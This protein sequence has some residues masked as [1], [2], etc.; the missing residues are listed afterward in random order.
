MSNEPDKSRFRIPA[1]WQG[2]IVIVIAYLV[3]DNAFPPVM[4]RTL[5]V[6][7]MI[8][9]IVGVLLFF[10][11]DEARWR[12]FKAPIFAV[13]RE[14]RLALVRWAFL[15][16]IPALIA[17]TTYTM[18]RPSVD[19]PVELRQVHPAPPSKL[20]VFGNTYDLSTLENP[21]RSEVLDK[22]SSDPDAA[23]QEYSEVVATGRDTY[24][25]NCFF[26]H[27]DLLDGDGPFA[28]GFNP[29]PINFQ[30]VGTIAQLQ[31]AFLFWR[32]TT[33][34][35]GLPKE[36][37]PWNS[38]MPVWHEMLDED[39]VWSIITFLYDYVGQVPRIWDGEM[40]RAV[41]GMKDTLVTQRKTMQGKDLY[42]LRCQVC[43]GE[44][45]MGDGP[46]ADFMYPR[47]RDFSLALFKYKTSPGTLPP[48][49]ED[50]FD[51]IKF[52]LHGT[53]MPAWNSLI[54]DEQITSLIPLIKRFDTSASW[55]P[56]DADD[57]AFDDDGYYTGPDLLTVTEQEPLDGRIPYSEESLVKGK[58][59][60]IDTCA[61]CHGDAGRG[62]IT[63]GKKLADDWGYRLWPRDLTK[64]WTWRSTE[65][66]GKDADKLRDQT[67]A[68]IYSR[69]SIGIPSTPMPAHRA[70]EA[71]NEDP[72][73]LE[74]RWHIANYVYS[75]RETATPPTDTGLITAR[76]LEGELPAN[77]DD[78]RWNEVPP[79]TLNLVPNII[80][81]PRLFTPLNDGVTVRVAY[82]DQDIVFLL[83]VDDRTKS[84]PGDEYFSDLMD[85]NLEMHSDALAVEFPRDGAF[86]TEPVVVKPLYRHG[87][88]AHPTTI[89]YWNA[90]SI[91][92]QAAARTAIIDANGP[93]KELKP[94]S[95]D[96]GLA[97]QGEWQ[98]GRWRIVMK[99]SRQG[100]GGDIS[101]SDGRFIPIAFANWDGS[102]GEAGSKHTLST[103][104]WLTLPPQADPLRTYGLPAVIGGLMFMVGLMLV[105]AQRK[106][107]SDRQA[108]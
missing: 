39:Q 68:N 58:R 66:S 97:A 75:L 70:V 89:W 1:F 82:N 47:P 7:Y 60:F 17:Y 25:Q 50:L 10:S 28:R 14:D 86:K 103:W 48:R 16:G 69:L 23:W 76:Y 30:D 71:G 43:H 64:P 85:E 95:G 15:L 94:R 52:G 61:Q 87:D 49:D 100:K 90:G 80:K 6:Q 22:L 27:G 62:N 13:L 46:A 107:A 53:A 24:Y 33:G 54:S 81:E 88:A 73:S 36:G 93:N 4:P 96:T 84:L 106:R 9:V 11:F 67:I 56:E 37:T 91:E 35:P 21:K 92:P 44:Q 29:L 20:K 26:C 2:V 102:N 34:G 5:M 83:E 31:E 41:T 57:E 104:Y 79:T 45:G 19:P 32:I 3:L 40:S 63:S 12:E 18:V 74:D 72:V 65:V 101:F 99:H 38:A 55:A 108:R 59:A 8:I 51:T 42:A 105:R 77:A 98:D 78:E